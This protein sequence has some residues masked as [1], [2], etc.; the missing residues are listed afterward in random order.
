[1][2]AAVR[3]VGRG[4]RHLNQAGYT[5]IWCNVVWALL[6]L[7]IVTAPAAWAGMIRL[8]WTAQ[9]TPT[10]GWADFWEG[11]KENFLRGVLI[12]FV[13]VVFFFITFTNLTSYALDDGIGYTLLR[14]VWILSGLMV[15]AVQLY[16]WPIYYALE[17][18]SIRGALRN[19]GVMILLNPLFTMV[20]LIA[21]ALIAT[22]STLLPLAWLLLSGGAF[23]AVTTAAVIDRLRVAGILPSEDPM[24]NL[25]DPSFNDV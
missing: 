18:P 16:M 22:F 9:R 8:S 12:A 24:S 17:K 7:L 13:N 23:A 20:V 3:A 1:M 5:Y 15:I 14:T 10:A 6:T 2:I 11:F 19:A 4:L 25:V 21:V